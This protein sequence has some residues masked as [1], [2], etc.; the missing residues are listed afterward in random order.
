GL[1]YLGIAC[2]VTAFA[3]QAYGQRYV[4]PE[5]AALIFLLEP[6]VAAF[7]A[8]ILLNEYLSVIQITGSIAIMSSIAMASRSTIKKSYR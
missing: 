1:I 5:I 8:W 4:K 7:F 6:V 3:L 2:S